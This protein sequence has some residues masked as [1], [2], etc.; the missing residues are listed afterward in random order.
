MIKFKEKNFSEYD[1]MRSLY[2]ELM[3]AARG[4]KNKYT[5]IDSSALIP[6]LKGNNVVIERFVIS[7]SFGHND[8]YRMYLK[9]GAK[10]KM[11]DEVRLPSMRRRERIADFDLEFN[12]SGWED[13]TTNRDAR[14]DYRHQERGWSDTSDNERVKLFSGDDK[15]H[16]DIKAKVSPKLDMSYEVDDILGDAIKYDKK[17][18]SLVLEFK[19]IQDAVH[20]LEVLPFGIDYKVYLL[21]L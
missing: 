7:T 17:D 1:A 3:K 13:D 12:G 19:T 16:P 21:N 11:P 5:I 4:D 2:V 20:A 15:Y 8:R 14:Q 10:A 18:R 6:V 9:V